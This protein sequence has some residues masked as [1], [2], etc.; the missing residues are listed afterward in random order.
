MVDE[1]FRANEGRVGRPFEGAPTCASPWPQEWREYVTP[2]MYQPHDSDP[3][4]VFVFA[5][6]GG[7]H[8]SP[9]W[10]CNLTAAGEGTIERG[11]ETYEVAVRD[12]TGAERDRIYAGQARRYPGFAAYERQT[13]GVRTIP[14]LELRRA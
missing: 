1:E 10:Y 14:V 8:I 11:T 7:A 4:I 12:L 9:D 6:K 2:V 13:V 5:T 3:D